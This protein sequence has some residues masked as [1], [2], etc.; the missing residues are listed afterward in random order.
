MRM[1]RY[2]KRK[3]SHLLSTEHLG[4]R[5]L[6]VLQ[7]N[8]MDSQC[9]LQL[10]ECLYAVEDTLMRVLVDRYCDKFG[11]SHADDGGHDQHRLKP[12]QYRLAPG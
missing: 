6:G 2:K 7:E 11:L 4:V 9:C 1:K 12:D 10:A 3:E 8:L 5:G